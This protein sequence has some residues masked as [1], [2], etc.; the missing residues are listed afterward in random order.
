M[1]DRQQK[2]TEAIKKQID[3]TRE[4]DQMGVKSPQWFRIDEIAARAYSQLL[5][6]IT[7]HCDTGNLEIYADP[8]LEKV[9][10]NLL[11]NSFRYGECITRIRISSTRSGGD[12]LLLFEDDG[13]G[14][15]DDE[16]EQIFLRGYGKNTGLGLYLTRE[17]LSI[18]GMNIWETGRYR[19][20][21]CFE[22]WVPEGNYRFLKAMAESQDCGNR[23]PI[24]ADD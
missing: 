9:F 20:G 12:L 24:C 22:I 16:K 5:Q 4:Y 1:L 3:F 8:M 10:Y 21:A 14:I 17:I 23:Q 19:T 2:A 13:I 15:P 6:T 7:F 11:D 18:T